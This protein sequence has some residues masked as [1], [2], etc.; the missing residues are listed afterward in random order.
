ML[1]IKKRNGYYEAYVNGSLFSYNEDLQ[2]LLDELSR[3][4][5]EL[6][7]ELSE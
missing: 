4:H 7:D 1:E 6:E 3:H 2:T 5:N